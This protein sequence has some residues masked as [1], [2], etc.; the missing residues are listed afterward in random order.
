MPS[1]SEAK[2]TKITRDPFDF[3]P[4]TDKVTY[5][6]VTYTFRELTVSEVDEIREMSID[7]D[8]GFDGRLM[9][10]LMIAKGAVEPTMTLD[11]L[12]KFPQSVYSLVV[13]CVNDLND[14]E[15]AKNESDPGN[16]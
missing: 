14:P 16:S 13:D 1:A 8:T 9:T 10:R 4:N 2:V 6:G 15:A 3:P 12:A 7:K 11:D 5:K